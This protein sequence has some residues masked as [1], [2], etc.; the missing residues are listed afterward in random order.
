MV[1]GIDGSPWQLKILDLWDVDDV[2]CPREGCVMHSQPLSNCDINLKQGH[3]I[4]LMHCS[5]F[6]PPALGISRFLS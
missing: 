1:G 5:I 4:N 6:P 2:V 3:Y